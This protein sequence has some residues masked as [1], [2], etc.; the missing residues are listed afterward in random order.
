MCDFVFETI[1]PLVSY[2]LSDDLS[3][4]L[5]SIPIRSLLKKLANL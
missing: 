2:T 5:G 3:D 4:I 1:I